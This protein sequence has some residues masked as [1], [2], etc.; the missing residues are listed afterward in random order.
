MKMNTFMNKPDFLS[1]KIIKYFREISVIV[2]GVAITLY[3]SN[4]LGNRNEKRD[5]SLY[6]NAIKLEMEDNIKHI[7]GIKKIIEP[8]IKYGDYIREHD[9]KSLDKDSIESYMDV[10]YSLEQFVEFKTSAFEM[11]KNSGAMR[12]M[13]NKEFLMSLWDVYQGLNSLSKSLDW[14]FQIKEEELKKEFSLILNEQTIEI[15]ML[16]FYSTGT[17]H[18]M[19]EPLEKALKMSEEIVI[20]LDKLF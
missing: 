7:E 13:N 8:N 17:A 15:P 1:A 9:K 5:I 2:I 19:V 18:L 10:I 14:Y 16:F 3:A 6:L 11:F 20:K 12:L 4:W